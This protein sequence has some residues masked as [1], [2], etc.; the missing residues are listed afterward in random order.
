MIFRLDGCGPA[1]YPSFKRTCWLSQKKMKSRRKGDQSYEKDNPGGGG[2]CQQTIP[3]IGPHSAIVILSEIGDFSLFQ[4]PKQLGVYF[5]LDPSQRQSGTFSGSKNRLS[6]RGSYYVCAA[7]HMSAVTA[8]IPQAQRRAGNPV[9]ASFYEEKRRTKP[10]QVA[11][12]AVMHKISN[13]IFAVLRD[14]KPF[15]LRQPKE[16]AQRLGIRSAA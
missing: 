14:Q 1:A 15:E 9:L 10:P 13:I 16:H 6:K 2:G 5:G 12:S 8:T 7:L 11:M 4:K 3:G